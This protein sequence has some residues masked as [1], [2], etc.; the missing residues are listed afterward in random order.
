M[1]E[2]KILHDPLKPKARAASKNFA[3]PTRDEA[4]TGRF[5][6]AGDYYGIGHK[7]PVGNEKASGLKSGP[8]PQESECFHSSLIT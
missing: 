1:S 4:T 5:M 7:N 2:K 8:I 3:A 6:Q